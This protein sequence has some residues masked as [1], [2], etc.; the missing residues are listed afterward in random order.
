M[1][2]GCVWVGEG[3]GCID[4]LGVVCQLVWSTCVGVGPSGGPSEYEHEDAG[5][6]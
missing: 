3:G 5:D 4:V 6:W 2:Q 1:G